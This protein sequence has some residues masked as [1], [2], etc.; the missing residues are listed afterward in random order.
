MASFKNKDVYDRLNQAID[1]GYPDRLDCFE[2]LP[3]RVNI[4]TS[5]S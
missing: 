2:E 5:R 4:Y 1:E 3:N